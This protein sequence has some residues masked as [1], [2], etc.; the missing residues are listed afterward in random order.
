ME[1]PRKCADGVG[2]RSLI[3]SEEVGRSELG[4]SSNDDYATRSPLD[5]QTRQNYRIAK[6]SIRYSMY[7]L[8]RALLTR[9]LTQMPPAAHVPVYSY[10]YEVFAHTRQ[11]S[12]IYDSD[13]T[14]RQ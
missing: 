2:R 8:T 12:P 7:I 3:G 13:L 14:D 1:V 4:V 10:L 5:T 9:L 11:R 6:L